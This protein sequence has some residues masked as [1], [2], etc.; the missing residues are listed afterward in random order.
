[1]RPI[2]SPRSDSSG[3]RRRIPDSTRLPRP[4]RCANTSATTSATVVMPNIRNWLRQRSDVR[5][6]RRHLCALPLGPL[7]HGPC[8]QKPRISGLSKCAREDSNLHGPF[9]PQGP[10]PRTRRVDALPSVQIGQ[11]VGFAGRVGRDGWG[12]CCHECCG[13]VLRWRSYG[14]ARSATSEPLA[15]KSWSS[16][17]A[18]PSRT[19]CC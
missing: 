15:P 14:G 9:S 3:V 12:G 7:D 8:M 17:N 13:R 4:L 1:M 18:R 10:Q 2:R 16:T 5:T 11:I 19:Q 6:D